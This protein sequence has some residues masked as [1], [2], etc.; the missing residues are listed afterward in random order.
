VNADCCGSVQT[1]RKLSHYRSQGSKTLAIC[2]AHIV[3]SDSFDAWVYLLSRTLVTRTQNGEMLCEKNHQ[4][5]YK[6]KNC[7]AIEEL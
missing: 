6:E 7:R 2:H 1:L 3:G 5:C 4:T